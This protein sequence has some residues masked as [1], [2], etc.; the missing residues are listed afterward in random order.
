MA[1]ATQE[2]EQLL[3]RFDNAVRAADVGDA[4]A[5]LQVFQ[6]MV[7]LEALAEAD[8]EREPTMEQMEAA[9]DALVP[10]A[11]A[12]LASRDAWRK[13]DG[14]CYEL[15]VPSD[16]DAMAGITQGQLDLAEK[17]YDALVNGWDL[18]H[19][20]P[21]THFRAMGRDARQAR[22]CEFVVTRFGHPN[23]GRLERA[24][25]VIEEALEIAQAEG[26]TVADVAKLGNYVYS[27]PVGKPSQ[28]AAGLGVALLAY[29][30]AI[31]VSADTVAA[32]EVERIFSK[33]AEYFRE[34]H[35][36]KAAAGV[37]LPCLPKDA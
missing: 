37:A 28:E 15:G 31:S 23:M 14:A 6:A 1:N 3:K 8:A 2:R 7:R 36:A 20:S 11:D 24:A 19:R 5:C 22:V 34:R 33:P 32:A 35:A 16:A 18:D 10:F 26:M 4:R 30:A 17:V 12:A 13:A 25:R 21:R 29:C 9:L 27:K